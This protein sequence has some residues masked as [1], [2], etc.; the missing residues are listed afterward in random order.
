MASRSRTL[1]TGVTND[2]ERRVWHGS[3]WSLAAVL[4]RAKA[5]KPGAVVPEILSLALIAERQL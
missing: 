4:S 2:L 5:V 1:Y 3:P